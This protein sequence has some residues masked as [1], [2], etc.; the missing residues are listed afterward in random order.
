MAWHNLPEIEAVTI[1][2]FAP[3]GAQN[4]EYLHVARAVVQAITGQFPEV[5]QVKH[6][7]VQWGI[8]K[9]DKAG[10]KVTLKGGQA[11]DFVDKLVTLVLPK[12]KDWKGIEATTGDSAGN[13]AFGM[14]PQWMAFFPEIE[15]NFDV[16]PTVSHNP[17]R[18]LTD[19]FR[20]TL[21]D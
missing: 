17:K 12:I 5:T 3:Y 10:C 9:G 11:Y 16:S 19:R 21:R 1:N 18:L 8:R 15:F 7:V 14:R 6:G 20:C 2:S 13:L 4:K